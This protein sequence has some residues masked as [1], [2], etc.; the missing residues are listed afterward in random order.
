[1][2]ISHNVKAIARDTRRRR[3]GSYAWPRLRL[4]AEQA[5]ARGERVLATILRLRERHAHDHAVVPSIRTMRRWFSQGRWLRHP[6]QPQPHVAAGP[7]TTTPGGR[8]RASQLPAATATCRCTQAPA[9]SSARRVMTH[10]RWRLYSVEPPRSASGLDALARV[11][12]GVGGRG[13]RGQRR[14]H[15]AALT[16][17]G[18]APQSATRQPPEPFETAA[19]HQRPVGRAA[20]ELGVRALALA[21]GDADLRDQVALVERRREVVDEEVVG[22]DRARRRRRCGRRSAR[23]RRARPQA[24][25][26]ADRPAPASRR[27]C[28]DCARAGR[29]SRRP[30]TTARARSRSP[31]DS[32]RRRGA[33]CRHR[34]RACRRRRGCP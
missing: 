4:E 1:M 12:R 2:P 19:R 16:A 25:R 24:D 18:P 22:R 11:R 26:R 8:R 3:P 20:V 32:R 17:V 33:A 13:A 30:P 28:R 29:R 10:A 9:A 23:P 27:S 6:A 34:S 5:F 21:R 31:R 7:L 15:T 14:L